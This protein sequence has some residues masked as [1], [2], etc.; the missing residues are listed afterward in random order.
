MAPSI[1]HPIKER[2]LNVN[3]LLSLSF[4]AA[5]S[6]SIYCKRSTV[7]RKILLDIKQDESFLKRG[8]I[9]F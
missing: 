6:N 7:L 8:R 2:G 1:I 9:N 5:A 3:K 4:D